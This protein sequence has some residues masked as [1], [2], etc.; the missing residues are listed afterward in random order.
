MMDPIVSEIAA[1]RCGR[2]LREKWT[3][4]SVLGVGGM[5][6]VY[7]AIHR[8]GSR[9]AIKMLHPALSTSDEIRHSFLREGYLLN[10]IEHPGV[11]RVHDDDVDDVDGSVYLVMDLLPGISLAERAKLRLLDA[12]E[13]LEVAEQVLE[14]LVA[15]HGRDIVHRDLKP[16]NILV[17]EGGAVRVVDFGIARCET[18]DVSTLRGIAGTAGYMAPEQV[19]GL[20]HRISPRTDLYALGAT[21]FTTL[22]GQSTHFA[23]NLQELLVRTGSSRARR[24]G[25]AAPGIPS[26]LAALIDRALAFDPADRWPSALDM[27]NEVQRLKARRGLPP[28]PILPEPSRRKV[29]SRIRV[30]RPSDVVPASTMDSPTLL[31]EADTAIPA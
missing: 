21:L 1:S 30:Q 4:T 12:D 18:S 27:L 20:R 3:L 25:D 17:D 7:A 23:E 28:A 9:V 10:R 13:A 24:I 16:Q 15:A 8:N 5:A 29:S 19:L 11:P 26:D 31:L 22:S 6:S 2:V 14:V